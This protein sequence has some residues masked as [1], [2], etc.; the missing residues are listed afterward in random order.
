MQVLK[1]VQ[2]L[3][4]DCLFDFENQFHLKNFENLFNFFQGGYRK[5]F[6]KRERGERA[7]DQMYKFFKMF[8]T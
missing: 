2:Q 3:Y 6:D 4:F 7:F 5:N 8:H 1:I